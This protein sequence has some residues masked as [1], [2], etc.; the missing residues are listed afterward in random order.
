MTL[1]EYLDNYFF[2]NKINIMKTIFNKLLKVSVLFISLASL[3][4][5]EEFIIED[6]RLEGLQRITPGTVFTYLPMKVGDAY[7][8]NKS[9][10]A[11][12]ALFKTEFFDDVKLQRDGNV[13]VFSFKE[14]PAIG[15]ISVLGNDDI[16]TEDLLD[17]LKQV[18]FAE[19]RVFVQSELDQ[20]E[21]ELRRQYFS[22]GKYAMTVGSSV[23]DLDENRV[24]VT[25]TVSEGVAAKIKKI[26]IIGND[27]FPEKKLLKK[28]QLSEPTL[29][30]FFTK[31]DQYSRQKLSADLETL[32]SYYL[33]FG[34]LNF[35]IDS[36]QVSL[37]PDKKDI[38]VTINVTEGDVYT[39]SEIKLAGDLTVPEEELYPLI[40]IAQGELFSRKLVSESSN[41]LSNRIGNDGYAFANVNSIPEIDK[42]NKT[43]ALTFF[44]D[45][46]KRAYVRRINFS[47]NSNTRD[48]VLRREMRQQ[49]G[50]WFSTEQVE[51]GKVRLGRL[52]FF[53]NINVETPSVA[54]TADQ[55]DVNYSVE[56]QASGNLSLGLGFSQ[57]SGIILQTSISQ[58]NFLGSGNSVSFAFNNSE[59]NRTFSLSFR[60]PY[61]TV[62][63][64]SRGYNAFYRETD[65]SNANVTRF[66]SVD[67]G[68]G[69]AIGFPI[70]EKNF[71]N[72]TVNYTNTD[73]QT[74][75]NSAAEVTSFINQN[76]SNFDTLTLESSF[77]YDTRNKA[78]L[79]DAGML[80]RVGAEISVP[81]FGNSLE[82]Y[83]L[84]YETQWFKS[85]YKDFVLSLRGNVGYGD[86]YSDTTELPFFQNFYAGG[87]RSIRGYEENTLGP[88]DSLNRPLG[89]D[90]RVVGNAEIIL[91][92]PFLADLDSVRISTF[93]DMGNVFGANE[94]FEFDRFRYSAG[95][96]GIWISPFG[97]VSVSVAQPFGDEPGDEIQNFQFTFGTSF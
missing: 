43:V 61:W 4:W 88:R 79:P 58:N 74:N 18:G 42:E 95:L 57:S 30:S 53:T 83:K 34:Y 64:I 5:A 63:G 10:E 73:I 93:V 80:H 69:L 35:N 24:G 56:E 94:D 39:V 76:G 36:T 70:S 54:G 40:S 77:R 33:D 89:G 13:L 50:A 28:F 75:S 82:Y 72:T 6:I 59:I 38:Y 68:G 49:E 29:F 23:V 66:D 86:A 81:F 60:D 2:N 45:P 3:V 91:P 1:L 41:N 9:T 17:S 55:V 37:T 85:L 78:I 48:E 15:S 11:I 22:L 32:R 96:S 51:R 25:I 19:G 92:I 46:G 71:I 44:V 97:A 87:P 16:K 12:R 27:A 14:R 62:D 20:V 90:T 65:A 7:D 8:E 84:R 67:W 52:G 47:G 21:K 26:N 31:N